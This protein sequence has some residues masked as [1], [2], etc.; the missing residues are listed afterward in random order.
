MKRDRIETYKFHRTKG[1]ASCRETN[2]GVPRRATYTTYT[3]A[4]TDIVKYISY[5]ENNRNR[6]SDVF[7]EN[8]SEAMKP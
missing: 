7:T 5:V 8:Q 1:S 3:R 6:S 2:I 4:R